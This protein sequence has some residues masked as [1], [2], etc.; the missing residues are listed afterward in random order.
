MTERLMVKPAHTVKARA[1]KAD[2]ER[3]S[4]F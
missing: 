2:P 1:E 4:E 3:A